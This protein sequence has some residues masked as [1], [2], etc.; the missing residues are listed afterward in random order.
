MSKFLIKASYAADGVRGVL[1]TGGSARK[2]A[3]EKSLVEVGGKLESFYFAFGEADVYA[4]AELPD[5]ISAAALALSINAS[6]M[7]SIST[8][9]LL[10]PQEVD[11]A[12]KLTVNYRM[13]GS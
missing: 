9:V 6:G 1:K 5:M 2:Q 13:P 8:T 12:I 10:D 11:E 3:V 7:V 4:V